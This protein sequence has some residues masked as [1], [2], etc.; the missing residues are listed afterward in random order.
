VSN[1]QVTTPPKVEPVS[2]PEIRTGQLRVDI[3][4]D[5][6]TIQ[7]YIRT[8]RMNLEREYNLAMLTQTLTLTLDTFA[9]PEWRRPG[10]PSSGSWMWP[11]SWSAWP[12]AWSIIQLRPPL[13]QVNSISYVD[14]SGNTQTLDPSVYTVDS[15][16][17]PA[18][19]FPALNKFWPMTALRPAAVTIVWVAGWT[20]PELVP[21]DIKSAIALFSGHLYE[22]REEVLVDRRLVAI[23]LPLGVAALMEPY[24]PA[25]YR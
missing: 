17:M 13:Q 4:E 9:Q 8:A 18:R 5:D 23:Q 19:L 3:P 6:A 16:S 1:I 12:W 22:N 25:N 20:I 10:W 15:N 21:D 2:I 11:G 7:R 14:S 24:A